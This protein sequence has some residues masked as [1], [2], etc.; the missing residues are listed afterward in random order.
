LFNTL[1]TF[2]VNFTTDTFFSQNSIVRYKRN[3]LINTSMTFEIQFITLSSMII[4]S[5]TV[6]YLFHVP[7]SPWKGVSSAD[8]GNDLHIRK[9][10]ANMLNKQSLVTDK[11]RTS[12]L[13]IGRGE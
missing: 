9:I 3:L 7:L 4:F 1:A 12:S 13:G 11:G 10:A 8:G 5:D 6:N 2:E